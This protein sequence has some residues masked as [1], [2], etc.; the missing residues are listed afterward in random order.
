MAD[1]AADPV[2]YHDKLARPSPMVSLFSIASAVAAIDRALAAAGAA[3]PI[4]VLNHPRIARGLTDR[5]RDVLLAAERARFRRRNS[6]AFACD[7]RSLPIASRAVAA[8]VANG[9]SERDDW[10]KRLAEWRRVVAAGGAIALV[11]QGVG[12]SRASEITR[13]ALC[14]GISDIEQRHAGRTL[15]T[16]GLVIHL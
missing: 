16:S 8:V 11:D 10:R 3:G 7:E 12:R 5:G 1:P 6:P 15:V 9:L 2:V 14:A 4:V 13:R